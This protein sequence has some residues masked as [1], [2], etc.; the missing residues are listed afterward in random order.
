MLEKNYTNPEGIGRFSYSESGNFRA[1]YKS[2]GLY[3]FTVLLIA[4]VLE[5]VVIFFA[6]SFLHILLG[7]YEQEGA[8]F[9][10]M[11][12]ALI[13]GIGTVVIFLIAGLIIAN[14]HSGIKCKFTATEEKF[15]VAVGGDT[16]V[17]NYNEVQSIVFMPRYFF[18]K[19]KGYDVDIT[20]ANKVQ[21]YSVCFRGQ[22]QSEKTTPYYIIKDR[23]EIIERRR[24]DE[25]ALYA[26]QKMGADKPVSQNEID[27]ARL[28]KKHSDDIFPPN[29]SNTAPQPKEKQTMNSVVPKKPHPKNVQAKDDFKQ[30]E[31]SSMR[32]PELKASARHK[33]V[34]QKTAESA[35]NFSMNEI[36]PINK[37]PSAN[38]FKDE[39]DEPMNIETNETETI[40]SEYNLDEPLLDNLPEDENISDDFLI[41]ANNSDDDFDEV[42]EDFLVTASK[43]DDL[44]EDVYENAPVIAEESVV[45]SEEADNIDNVDDNDEQTSP[46][47][48]KNK[49]K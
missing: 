3:V 13:I 20:I 39:T 16:H 31:T 22:Y 33:T 29:H 37:R 28:R 6:L 43:P 18:G 45:E 23:L 35:E 10:A 36:T 1:P 26:Q 46:E 8:T 19:I 47:L 30:P 9:S 48:K 34:A 15:V 21:Q 38:M 4:A 40:V 49:M 32:M 42:G 27:R 17:I 5:G 25:A 7:E 41:T 12:S 11:T 24:S 44:E 14:I 2:E